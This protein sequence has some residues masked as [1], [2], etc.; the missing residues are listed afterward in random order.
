MFST[1]RNRKIKKTSL[2]RKH[3]TRRNQRKLKGGTLDKCIKTCT[4]NWCE[5]DGLPTK[6]YPTN[7]GWY[8]IHDETTMHGF[9]YPTNSLHNNADHTKSVSVLTIPKRNGSTIDLLDEFKNRN[10]DLPYLGYISSGGYALSI[11]RNKL[12]W[13][14]GNDAI[15]PYVYDEEPNE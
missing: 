1:R 3:R 6:K 15:I 7:H 9:T 5:W 2:K 12:V 10:F 14:R 11:D 4:D 8:I 13:K